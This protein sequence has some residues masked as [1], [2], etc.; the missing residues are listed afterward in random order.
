MNEIYPE[1]SAVFNYDKDYYVTVV[2]NL[3]TYS[4]KC[5]NVLYFDTAVSFSPDLKV[6]HVWADREYIYFDISEPVMNNCYKYAE[7][8]LIQFKSDHHG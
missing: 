3:N 1:C 2:F 8:A 5:I 4:I 7:Q 6:I